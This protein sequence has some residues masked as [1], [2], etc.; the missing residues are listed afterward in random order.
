MKASVSIVPKRVTTESAFMKIKA[1]VPTLTPKIH[2]CAE[3]VMKLVNKL[4]K[5]TEDKRNKRKSTG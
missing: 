1:A 4:A 2:P 5:D 3:C